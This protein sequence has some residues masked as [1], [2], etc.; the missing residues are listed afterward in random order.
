MR[1]HAGIADSARRERR[2]QL[3]AAAPSIAARFP[4]AGRFAVELEFRDPTGV[5]TPSPFRQIYEPTMPAYF[6]LRCPV[7]ECSGGFELHEAIS[8][9]LANH[10]LARS[11]VAACCGLRERNGAVQ[12]C[13]LELSY[14]LVFLDENSTGA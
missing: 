13:G 6:D 14:A 4:H 3:R 7:H 8:A 12:P 9:M 11:G 2:E 1:R 10:K 5:L